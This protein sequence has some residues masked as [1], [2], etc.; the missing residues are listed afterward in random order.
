MAF[1][2]E[3][4]RINCECGSEE[5]A[6]AYDPDGAVPTIDLAFWEHGHNRYR[7]P[8]AYILRQI[9]QLV[10]VGHPYTDMV[11]LNADEAEKMAT[12]LWGM[13]KRMRAIEEEKKKKAV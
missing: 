7:T 4:V 9:V 5:I 10:K 11:L 12:T 2:H 8:L 13:A 6:I 3:E 1:M